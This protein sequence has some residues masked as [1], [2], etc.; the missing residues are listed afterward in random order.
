MGRHGVRECIEVLPRRMHRP[1][2]NHTWSTDLEVAG[3]VWPI[4]KIRHLID[5]S[6]LA[7]I[8]FTDHSATVGFVKQTSLTSSSVDKF[9]LRLLQ[10]S[11]YLSQFNLEVRYKP[12]KQHTVPDALSRLINNSA[13]ERGAM[14]SE[15]E[16][17]D[18]VFG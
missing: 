17:L 1:W 6:L 13:T 5:N 9:N 16:I 3:L 11:Q 12:V 14:T 15:E 7:V 2:R 8:V 18:E 4:R 10:A